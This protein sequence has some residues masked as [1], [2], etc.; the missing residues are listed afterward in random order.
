MGGR[1]G[2]WTVG[3]VLECGG[4]F[5]VLIGIVATDDIGTRLSSAKLLCH[6]AR[7]QLCVP[8]SGHTLVFV[9][10]DPAAQWPQRQAS[11]MFHLG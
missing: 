5:A 10:L 9:W 1:G 2:L 4:L 11:A 8:I 7:N 6:L 3:Q